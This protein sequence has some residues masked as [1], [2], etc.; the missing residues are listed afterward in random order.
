MTNLSTKGKAVEKLR[1]NNFYRYNTRVAS[2]RL[3]VT[4]F[5]PIISSLLTNFMCGINFLL[6]FVFLLQTLFNFLNCSFNCY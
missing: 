6:I 5:L 2:C 3:Y 1:R 4:F